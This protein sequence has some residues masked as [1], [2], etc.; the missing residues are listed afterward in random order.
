MSQVKWIPIE[1]V[2]EVLEKSKSGQWH[3]GYNSKC[4]YIDLRIDMRDGHCVLK[5]RNGSLITLDELNYQIGE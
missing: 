1:R 5:D 3:W 2:I 4:K